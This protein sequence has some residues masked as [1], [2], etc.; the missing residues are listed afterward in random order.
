MHSARILLVTALLV[1]LRFL[2]TMQADRVRRACHPPTCMHVL[3]NDAVRRP[4]YSGHLMRGPNSR[5]TL[6]NSFDRHQFQMLVTLQIL[7]AIVISGQPG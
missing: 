2:L 4:L 3:A 7:Y 5:Q 6:D 1:A